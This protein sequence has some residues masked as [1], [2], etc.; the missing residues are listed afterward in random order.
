MA[1]PR[2]RQAAVHPLLVTAA[3]SS[4]SGGAPSIG[5]RASTRRASWK[6]Q[7][8]LA[9]KSG[10]ID[11]H[12][13]YLKFRKREAPSLYPPIPDFLLQKDTNNNNMMN[14]SFPEL[15]PSPQLQGGRPTFNKTNGSTSS[16]K[17]H[18]LLEDTSSEP[19]SPSA[20]RSSLSSV[21]T[22]PTIT[23]DCSAEDVEAIQAALLYDK[24]MEE[25]QSKALV[26]DLLREELG[27]SVSGRSSLSLPSRDQPPQNVASMRAQ[28]KSAAQDLIYQLCLKLEETQGNVKAE[29]W[30][31]LAPHEI[32]KLELFC[33][34]TT[35]KRETQCH[36][37]SSCDKDDDEKDMCLICQFN[38]Q[39]ND[40][41]R[42]LRCSH[43]FHQECVDPW[44]LERDICPV[45]RKPIDED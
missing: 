42:R 29:Q 43:M 32:D 10:T 6:Q 33:Y 12:L 13:A 40:S 3:T 39:Q 34:G 28:T 1:S 22:L 31:M 17:S 8:Q 27:L 35:G 7:Q 44:L 26:H 2:Q 4:S 11:D 5:N 36:N 16:S 20:K 30:K 45:C 21:Q 18:R 38:Y 41:V 9:C 23:S 37:N 25:E 19:S 24:E 14:S 15:P